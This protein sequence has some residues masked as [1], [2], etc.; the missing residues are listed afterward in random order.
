MWGRTGGGGPGGRGVGVGGFWW[1]M[2]GGRGQMG[3]C[4]K[5]EFCAGIPEKKIGKKGGGGMKEKNGRG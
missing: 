4:K 5:S 1:K 2:G 3:G